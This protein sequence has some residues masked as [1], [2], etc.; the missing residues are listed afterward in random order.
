MK[1]ANPHAKCILD[2][3]HVN[4]DIYLSWPVSFTQLLSFLGA[5]NTIDVL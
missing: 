4:T 5:T 1:I 2:T 3:L